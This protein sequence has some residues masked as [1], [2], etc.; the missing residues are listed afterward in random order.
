MVH[1]PLAT[2]VVRPSPKLRKPCPR[3]M[4]KGAP[5]PPLLGL[6]CQATDMQGRGVRT[7]IGSSALGVATG[8][9]MVAAFFWRVLPSPIDRA[10]GIL[11]GPA[12]WFAERWSDRN[13]GPGLLSGSGFL[14]CSLAISTQWGL[15]GALVGLWRCRRLHGKAAC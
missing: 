7:V 12:L 2:P 8:L 1:H 6:S 15:L 3:P 13:S 10:L 5:I 11:N 4:R 14:A 9:V